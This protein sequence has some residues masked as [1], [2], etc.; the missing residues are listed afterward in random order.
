MHIFYTDSVSLVELNKYMLK[1]T[2]YRCSTNQSIFTCWLRQNVS[3]NLRS[4]PR[5][6]LKVWSRLNMNWYQWWIRRPTLGSVIQEQ[7]SIIQIS[8]NPFTNLAF[9]YPVT[10]MV[11][12]HCHSFYK[13]NIDH[14]SL[15]IFCLSTSISWY[16]ARFWDQTEL[17]SFLLMDEM[18]ILDSAQD[19][20]LEAA[21]LDTRST[22]GFQMLQIDIWDT[23]GSNWCL[24]T[25]VAQRKKHHNN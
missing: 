2:A 19:A 8:K 25:S 1:P 11:T 16:L 24:E 6:V 4:H 23:S 3:I 17:H 15:K 22:R 21:K 20:F 9:D 18:P 14:T 12:L 10:T 13:N 7:M 5:I